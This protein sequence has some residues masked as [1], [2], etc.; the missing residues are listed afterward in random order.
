MT[1]QRKLIIL[2]LLVSLIP[3]LI[4]GFLHRTTIQQISRKLTTDTRDL[5]QDNTTQQL[6]AIVN[7]Q[8]LLLKRDREFI[9]QSIAA[10]AR[11]VENL[12]AAQNKPTNAQLAEAYL[13]IQHSN[14]DLFLWQATYL[15]SG[16]NSIF[17]RKSL[18]TDENAAWYKKIVQAK[19]AGWQIDLVD[20]KL[21]ISV[22]VPLH[23]RDGRI[24]GTTAFALDYKQFFNDWQLPQLWQ[25]QGRLFVLSIDPDSK[26]P[27][28]KLNII[29]KI[30]NQKAQYKAA[31]RPEKSFYSLAPESSIN[32]LVETVKTNSTGTLTLE[33]DGKKSIWVYAGATPGE[34][35]PLLLIPQELVS[36]PADAAADYVEEQFTSE[37]KFT[38]ILT[39]GVLLAV[40]II[41]IQRARAVTRPLSKLVNAAEKLSQGD[42]SVQVDIQSRDEFEELGETFNRIGP[43]LKERQEIKQSLAVAK[44]IQQLILPVETP[45]LERFDIASR[46]DYCDETGGDYYDYIKMS[47]GR[48]GLAVGD[49]VGHGVGAALLMASAAGILHAAIAN[50][51]DNLETLFSTLNVF[52]EKDVGDIRFMTLF[53]AIL[54]PK[55][56]SLQWLSAGHGPMFLYRAATGEVTELNATTMPLGVM[57]DVEFKPVQHETLTSGDILAVGTDGIW[58]STSPTGELFGSTRVSQLL[59]DC[60]TH[61]AEEIIDN[62]LLQVETFRE[63]VPQDDDITLVVLKAL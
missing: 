57:N 43:Q 12:L 29:L 60:A 56:Q 23:S 58:E 52:L 59:K 19:E 5:L 30:V 51:E 44:D 62:I 6:L 63:G 53:F 31:T 48:W 22:Y 9:S 50:G 27:A 26:V 41:A 14:P 35:F 40:I 2:L 33:F 61:S 38:A 36:L 55:K 39:L 54:D 42:F 20:S 18:P 8:S 1:F 17:P 16:Q 45:D 11:E 4:N 34:P 28:K 49:V 21:Q 3:L 32:T 13:T 25:E 46:I 24:V 10:Q 37:L 7:N 15:K 47:S